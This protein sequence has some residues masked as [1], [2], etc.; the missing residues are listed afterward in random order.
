MAR[1]TLEEVLTAAGLTAVWEERGKARWKAE[2]RAEGE[3]KGSLKGEAKGLKEALEMLRS[4]KT[5]KE[6]EKM[7][8]EK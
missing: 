3:A 1:E 5:P 8:E 2:G 6:I 7:Y 4:G